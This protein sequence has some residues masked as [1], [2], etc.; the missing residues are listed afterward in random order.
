M[1]L[2]A[3]CQL[4]LHRVLDSGYT[5]STRFPNFSV[6]FQA[7]INAAALSNGLALVLQTRLVVKISGPPL[8]SGK[9]I[10][11]NAK[12]RRRKRHPNIC[13]IYFMIPMI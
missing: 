3:Q 8:Q 13:N 1:L 12:A 11:P 9:V 6:I 2:L 10:L 4:G 5:C 7:F